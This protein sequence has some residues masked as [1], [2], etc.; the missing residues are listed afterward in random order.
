MCKYMGWTLED[1][2]GVS[3]DYYRELIE[4]IKAESETRDGG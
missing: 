3:E 4:M 1:L 2:L